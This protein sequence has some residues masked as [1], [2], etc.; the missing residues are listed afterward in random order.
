MRSRM[1]TKTSKVHC[2]PP[3]QWMLVVVRMV[4]SR[5]VA[6]VLYAQVFHHHRLLL[7]CE[8]EAS[9]AMLRSSERVDS[10]AAAA[11]AVDGLDAS[12]SWE[13]GGTKNAAWTAG[14]T[15]SGWSAPC[16]FWG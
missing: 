16:N 3:M 14:Q 4:P 5:A 10:D 1:M 6:V 8:G 11:A 2:R 9:A 13:V 7:P 12:S 15:G